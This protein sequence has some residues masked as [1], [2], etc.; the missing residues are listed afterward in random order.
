MQKGIKPAA[1]RKQPAG[2]Q[3]RNRCAVTFA[4][5]LCAIA[6]GIGTAL[7]IKGYRMRYARKW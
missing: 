6:M 7:R 1:Q 4:Q 2:S 5:R 3:V